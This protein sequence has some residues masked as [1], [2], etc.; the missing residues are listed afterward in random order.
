MQ[1]PFAAAPSRARRPGGGTGGR[2]G[3]GSSIL[4]CGRLGRQE[5]CTGGGCA[6]RGRA[7]SSSRCA[8]TLRLARLLCRLHSRQAGGGSGQ[9]SGRGRG[10]ASG[11]SGGLRVSPF[12]RR[13]GA[14]VCARTCG[15][16]WRGEGTSGHDC[17]GV[18]QSRQCWWYLTP[19]WGRSTTS[20]TQAVPQAHDRQGPVRR[21]NT[22]EGATI[23]RRRVG[24]GLRNPRAGSRAGGSR[25]WG[26]GGSEY[27]GTEWRRQAGQRREDLEARKRQQ[28]GQRS[29][30]GS[31]VRCEGVWAALS[32]IRTQRWPMREWGFERV[33]RE[34]QAEMAQLQWNGVWRGHSDHAIAH[35]G[36]CRRLLGDIFR[37]HRAKPA[38]EFGSMQSQS[39]LP[40]QKQP[41]P[42]PCCLR[43][44]R[45]G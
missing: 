19:F 18:R 40:R 7:L 36:R 20:T 21:W 1:V 30:K 25:V 42:L 32:F 24:G 28:A 9:R 41:E 12:G 13:R 17:D 43:H 34:R 44:R 37:A 3:G 6:G 15:G 10:R 45:H 29:A 31:A 33:G 23:G 14:A 11:P 16:V 2:D 4:C 22:G 38:K 5:G 8:W 39:H 35:L 26:G 27:L